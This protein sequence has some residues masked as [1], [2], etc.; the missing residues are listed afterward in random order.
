ME[1][2]PAGAILSITTDDF[3]E[4]RQ[5]SVGWDA[6]YYLIGRGKPRIKTF[7]VM[8]QS[9][10]L[11]LVEHYLGYSAQGNNPRGCLTFI[12]PLDEDQPMLHRSSSLD[13]LQMGVT[14][15][16]KGFEL[17]NPIGSRHLLASVSQTVLEQYAADLRREPLRKGD[18]ADRIGFQNKTNRLQ[19]VEACQTILDA[20]QRQPDLLANPRSISL[21]EEKLL[22]NVVL[23]T[24]S[25]L[26]DSSAAFR[27]PVARRAFAYLQE[28]LEAVPSIRDICARTGASYA[29][30][31][32]GFRE[33]YGMTPQAYLNAVRLSRARR[34]LRQPNVNTN[35]SSVAIHWGFLELG[36]FSV[37]YR[38]RFGETPSETLRKARG[39]SRLLANHDPRRR[40]A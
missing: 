28:Q 14:H 29:T 15:S 1:G 39:D 21:L 37:Q 22:T 10:Q 23:Q 18:F 12:V 5:L 19:Y 27:Y 32:R 16:G 20:V 38:Q 24:S 9:V 30:L 25:E 36:R 2:F 34:E 26:S 31:E 13:N 8:T 33:T 3:D 17:V 6:D 4:F 11:A 7:A 35:V 40:I